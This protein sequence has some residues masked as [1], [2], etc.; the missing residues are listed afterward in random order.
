MR[1]SLEQ[2]LHISL[3]TFD[4]P[5]PNIEL[6]V[7]YKQFVQGVV[8]TSLINSSKPADIS[9]HEFASVSDVTAALAFDTFERL[10]AG[11]TDISPLALACTKDSA[12]A[13][14]PLPAASFTDAQT[15][16]CLPIPA[17]TSTKPRIASAT[18][19]ISPN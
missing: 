2:C 1:S 11:T 5:L 14:L 7:P 16:D 4:T 17:N 19:T 3:H 8:Y 10:N 6:H 13:T 15:F 18:N 9:A 12:E